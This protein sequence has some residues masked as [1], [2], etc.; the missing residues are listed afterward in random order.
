[1]VLEQEMT[2]NPNDNIE[3]SL[4]EQAKQS[5]YKYLKGKNVTYSY[6]ICV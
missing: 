4:S 6:N 1:M 3:L 2:Q 5:F